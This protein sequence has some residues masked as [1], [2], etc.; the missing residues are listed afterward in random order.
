MLARRVTYAALAVLFTAA[1][2]SQRNGRPGE[3]EGDQ[4]TL[5]FERYRLDNG[6]EVILHQDRR[7]PL[8]A[9]SVWYHVGAINEQKGRSGFAHLFEHMMFQASPHVPEDHFFKILQQVGATGVNGTTGFDRT[10]YFAT[11]PSNEL[12]TVLWLE[13][14]RMGFLLSSV[15][16]QSLKNQIDVVQN[17][18]RQSVENAPYG[19]MRELIVKTLYPEPH[20]YFGS[21]IGSMEDIA[22]A[23]LGDVQEFFRTYYTPANATLVLAGDFE[24]DAAKKLVERYFGTLK[25]RPA[26]ARAEL[27]APALDKELF[28]RFDEP[29]A[30]LPKLSMVW[31]GPSAFQ[32]DTAELDLLAHVI[33]GTRS[34][35]LDKRVTFDDLIAQSVTAHFS[36]HTSGGQFQIDLVVRPGRTLEEAQAAVEEVLA[37]LRKN[38]PN[39]A[40]L[41]RAK[42]TFETQLLEGLQQLGGFSG[43]AERLQFYNHY[44]R[45]PGRLAWDVERYRRV[46]TEDLSRVLDRYLGSERLIVHGVP[47]AQAA[48]AG[49][50]R[51]E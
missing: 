23:T 25:G 49:A 29:V 18:R 1:C 14:D 10:N 43:R 28:I 46:T 48:P 35:R 13:S 19:L 30:R 32:P 3:A 17:E 51:E 2:A 39:Q 33:S 6:L 26:P 16:E 44:L 21:V 8:A 41:A 36:E 12:E 37:D 24:V 38:P 45:D 31:M 34:S 9:V 20:P 15:T 22:A 5:A 4:P 11:V 40:E 27:P 42:N 50:A 47:A 7:L